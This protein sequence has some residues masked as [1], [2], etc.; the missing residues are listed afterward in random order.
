[1]NGGQDEKLRSRPTHE[2][3]N[4]DS[5]RITA[6]SGT[7]VNNR[8][9]K[10]KESGKPN[11]TSKGDKYSIQESWKVGIPSMIHG[12]TLNKMHCTS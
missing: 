4:N 7:G 11:C 1:M 2:N 10:D 3:G 5:H 9:V 12:E 8:V 6:D